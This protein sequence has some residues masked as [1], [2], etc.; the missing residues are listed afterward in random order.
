MHQSHRKNERR[1][2]LHHHDNPFLHR[3]LRLG[4]KH[5]RDASGLHFVEAPRGVIQA[6]E[7]GMSVETIVYSETLCWI[8]GAQKHVRHAKRAG[9][10]VV[11]LT[12]EQ[13]RQISR[14]P[15]ASGLGAIVRQHWTS[16]D[17]I[18]PRHGLCWVAVSRIRSP[19]NLGT[20]LRTAEAIG[21]AGALFLGEATDPFHPDVVRATMGSLFRLQLVRTTLQDFRAWCARHQCRVVGT[22]PSAAT[23]YTEVPLE[24][25]LVVFFGEER[26]G[27][28]P[29]EIGLCT[30]TARIPILGRSDSLN[31]GVAAGVMLYEVLRRVEWSAGAGNPM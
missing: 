25:P 9:V 27:M 5:E 28:G 6:L 19:G 15:R 30:H 12:P 1:L 31:V 8:P 16:L 11:R 26:E 3:I 20:I 18:D 29:E 22:S 4:L 10:P 7:A 21:A 23:L 14:T 24:R 17:R 2:H 13:F